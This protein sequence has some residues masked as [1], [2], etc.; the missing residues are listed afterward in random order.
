MDEEPAERE[1]KNGEL[2]RKSAQNLPSLQSLRHENGRSS[3]LSYGN[4]SAGVED[5]MMSLV[6][7]FPK[8]FADLPYNQAK[9]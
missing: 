1:I 2:M 7:Y 5:S 3:Q 4:K 8:R 6:Q 9:K